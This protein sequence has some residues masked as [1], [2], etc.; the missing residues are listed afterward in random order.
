MLFFLLNILFSFFIYYHV[1]HYFST[2]SRTHVRICVQ[3]ATP[4]STTSIRILSKKRTQYIDVRK[5]KT[6]LPWGW[7]LKLYNFVANDA[8][9][10]DRK[11]AT[12]DSQMATLYKRHKLNAQGFCKALWDNLKH[13]QPFASFPMWE[14]LFQ[15]SKRMNWSNMTFLILNVSE[16]KTFQYNFPEGNSVWENGFYLSS[17]Q[18]CSHHLA[19]LVPVVTGPESFAILSPVFWGNTRPNLRK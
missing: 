6:T 14:N 9:V 3:V 19:A 15:Q 13:G 8:N 2:F 18:K 1:L 10:G 5:P 4:L 11:C 17:T 12:K 7:K 16:P